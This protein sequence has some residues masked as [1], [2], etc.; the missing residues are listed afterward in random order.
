[1]HFDRV[2]LCFAPF[3]WYV[4]F[5]ESTHHDIIVTCAP[6]Y[7][8]IVMKSIERN[9]ETYEPQSELRFTSC[10]HRGAVYTAMDWKLISKGA[11]GRSNSLITI[12]LKVFDERTSKARIQ[13][14]NKQTHSI[15]PL[16]L[17]DVLNPSFIELRQ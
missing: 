16:N 9:N 1:M 4:L 2:G 10:M 5:C 7:K 12:D 8:A 13:K 14:A 6:Q 11:Y 3:L 15:Y 17:Y